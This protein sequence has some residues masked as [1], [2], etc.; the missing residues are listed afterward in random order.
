MVP[1]AFVLYAWERIS[2]NLMISYM[3]IYLKPY[4]KLIFD[5]TPVLLGVLVKAFDL[6]AVWSKDPSK[7]IF[8]SCVSYWDH[9]FY[10]GYTTL[11]M[12]EVGRSRKVISRD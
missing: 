2:V 9:T 5:V 8:G 11:Q 6:R 10:R 4:S 1:L 12:M 3:C 7:S